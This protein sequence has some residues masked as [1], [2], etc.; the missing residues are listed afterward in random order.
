M[1]LH[2]RCSRRVL[3]CGRRQKCFISVE[4]KPEGTGEPV[5]IHWTNPESGE[6][7]VELGIYTRSVPITRDR[8][9]CA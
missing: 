6:E 4:T 9:I 2:A 5:L 1:K 7:E 8:R 3:R